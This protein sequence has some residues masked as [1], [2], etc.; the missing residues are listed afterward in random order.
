[1]EQELKKVGVTVCHQWEQYIASNPDGFQ[2]SQ[3]RHHY[4]VWGKKVNPVMHMNHKAGDKMYVD[5][6][7]KTISIVDK[8][9]GEIKE[10]QFF[11]AILGASQYIYAEASMSQQKE[12]FVTSVENA[13]RFLK[14][15]L[16]RLFQTI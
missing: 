16:L 13:I 3:F 15:L 4:K 6:T 14:E 1:M 9:T 11:V 7:G 5:Y 10:V 12:D 8:N 2:S